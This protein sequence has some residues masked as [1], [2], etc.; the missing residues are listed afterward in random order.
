MYFDDNCLPVFPLKAKYDSVNTDIKALEN[1]D[2]EIFVPDDY[3][4]P[5]IPDSIYEQVIARK[6]AEK[7]RQNPGPTEFL[8]AGRRFRNIQVQTN[9]GHLGEDSPKQS[10]PKDDAASPD[11]APA[12]QPAGPADSAPLGEIIVVDGQKYIVDT[13]GRRYPCDDTGK[14]IY[15]S[16]KPRNVSQVNWSSASAEQ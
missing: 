12:D 13:I 7:E 3:I 14:R 15:R 2:E 9:H 6:K 4:L 8:D 1:R 10:E 11:N 16:R 5:D